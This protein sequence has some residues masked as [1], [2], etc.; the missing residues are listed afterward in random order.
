[1]FS[2]TKD[3]TML[4][5][6]VMNSHP[7]IFCFSTTRSGGVGNGNYSSFNCSPFSGDDAECVRRNQEILLGNMPE[8]S[9]LIIPHQVHGVEVAVVDNHLLSLCDEALREALEGVDALVS[10]IRGVCLC[11]STADCV[12]VLMYDVRRGVVGAA[13]AG[14]RGTLAGIVVSTVRRMTELYGSSPE[15]IVACIGPSISLASFEVGNEVVEAFRSGGYDMD[16][17]TTGKH[18]I[19]LWE[20][21]RQQLTGCGVKPESIETAGICTFINH[22]QFFSA[23]RLGINSG[24]ILSGIMMR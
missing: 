3:K 11:I 16:N 15:D 6:E 20:V 17:P 8:D 21:N 1:M 2:L 7:D 18:H 19:D 12:P 23:R 5:F 10:D 24:R 22:D 14:W 9:R 13:H 4:G